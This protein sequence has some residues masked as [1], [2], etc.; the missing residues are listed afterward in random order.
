VRAGFVP[1]VP[2]I[3]AP[4]ERVRAA[5][6]GTVF[7]FPSPAAPVLEMIDGIIAG[8][9]P[10]RGKNATPAGF[11]PASSVRRGAAILAL[12]KP[13]LAVAE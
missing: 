12:N 8:R 3:G 5:R 10:A 4:A 2:D 11:F 6:Y 1:L 13:A 7:P 9:L